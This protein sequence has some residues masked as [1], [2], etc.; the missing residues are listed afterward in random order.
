MHFSY[1]L[2]KEQPQGKLLWD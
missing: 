2:Q 1:V